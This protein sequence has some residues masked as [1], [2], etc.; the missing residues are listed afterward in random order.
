MSSIL[1]LTDAYSTYSLFQKSPKEVQL[2]NDS[3]VIWYV[4]GLLDTEH[5]F[6]KLFVSGFLK[7]TL[8]FKKIK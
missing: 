3:L 6:Q 8:A 4:R 1:S 5:N 7:G 2:I